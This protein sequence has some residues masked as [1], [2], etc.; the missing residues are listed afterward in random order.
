MTKKKH[1]VQIRKEKKLSNQNK[2]NRKRERERAS[3]EKTRVLVNNLTPCPQ[4]SHQQEHFSRGRS[5]GHAR[6]SK[7]PGRRRIPP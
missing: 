6:T 2:K 3:L 1:N 5:C 4:G 7:R